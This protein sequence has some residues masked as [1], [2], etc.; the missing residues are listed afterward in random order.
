MYV[1]ASR[2]YSSTTGGALSSRGAHFLNTIRSSSNHLLNIINDI[3]DVAALKEGKMS[4]K[5]ENVDLARAT[6]HVFDILSPVAKP[7]V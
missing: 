1:E 4:I 6:T 2:S 3:L 5:H 7:E